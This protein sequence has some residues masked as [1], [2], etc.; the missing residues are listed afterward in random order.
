MVSFRERWLAAVEDKNSVLCAGL[1]PAEFS[2][3]RGKKGLPPGTNKRDWALRYVAAVAPYCA[4]VKPNFQFW[5][6]A[7]DVATLM[8]VSLLADHLGLVVIDDSKLADI[9]DTNE[10]GIYFTARRGGHAVTIAPY[11][12]NMAEA[13]IQG[14]NAGVGVITM[15][16][17]SNPDYAR[18]K[19]KLVAVDEND[20]YPSKDIVRVDDRPFV[21]QFMV[22]ANEARLHGLAGIVIGA[23]SEKNHLTDEE[24]AKARHYSGDQMLVLLPGVGAQGGEAAK[25]WKYY[26]SDGVIVNV[27]RGLMFPNG[28]T[29]AEDDWKAKAQE[30]QKILNEKRN[31]A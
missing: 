11:A 9:G 4:A 26:P 15:C 3:G 27:G 12:G 2:M 8:E 13:Q 17:M 24:L 25:I 5:K 7:E 6:G 31:A 10:A 29:S 22:N 1:D 16:L 14:D 28:A 18:E 21:R 19:N 20:H 23:P 30:Y